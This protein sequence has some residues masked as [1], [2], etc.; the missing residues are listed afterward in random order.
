MSFQVDLS[1]HTSKALKKR[2]ITKN[3]LNE[4]IDKFLDW[5]EKKNVNIDVH[6]MEGIWA[7][8]HRIR[9]GEMR[10]ILKI[11]YANHTILIERIATRGEAYKK[12]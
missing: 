10:V 4:V 8:F 3:E 12:K 1:K 6:E 11:D 2:T 5:T 9:I 7:G